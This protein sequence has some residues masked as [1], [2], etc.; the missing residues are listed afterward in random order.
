MNYKQGDTVK[1][2]KIW[3]PVMVVITDYDVLIEEAKADNRQPS[4]SVIFK[5][6]M[7]FAQWFDKDDR[8]QEADVLKALIW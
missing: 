4:D 7:V 8:R 1:Y 3:S 6:G 5:S 2:K